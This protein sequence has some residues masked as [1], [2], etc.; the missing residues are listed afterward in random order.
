MALKRAVLQVLQISSFRTLLCGPIIVG[1]SDLV[2]TTQYSG[3]LKAKYIYQEYD[4]PTSRPSFYLYIYNNII[5]SY[6]KRH[7]LIVYILKITN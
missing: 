2:N 6:N 3:S 1:F 7:R 4:F 5:R